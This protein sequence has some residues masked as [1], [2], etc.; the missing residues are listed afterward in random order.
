MPR[1]PASPRPAPADPDEILRC[2]HFGTCGGCS[3]LDQPIRW[4]LHDKVAACERDLAP[5]LG[6]VRID[7][8][9][10]KRP[11]RH[12]RT[13]LL[14]PVLPDHDGLPIV[15]LYGFRSHD[16]VQIE[17]CSTQDGWLTQFGRKA[18][19]VLRGLRLQPF[20]ARRQ[21]GNVKAIWARLA[22]GT[23]EVLAGIVTRPGAFTEG[24]AFAK[25]LVEAARSLPRPRVPRHLQGV[26][27]SI[28]DGDDEFLLGDR[29]VPLRGA[30]HVI[31][32]RDG[33]AFRVSAGSFYQI[34]ADAHELLYR[35]AIAM[36]GD[37]RGQRVVD[38][39]GGVGA[40]GLRL[41]KAGAT[42][43]T[44]VEEGAAACR[45]AEHNAALNRLGGVRVVRSPVAS[46]PLPRQADLMVL[47]PPRAGLQA[48]ACARVVAAAPRRILYVSCAPESLARDLATLRQA[49][50]RVQA[51]RLC[52]LFPHT[53]HCELVVALTS[54]R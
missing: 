23:G 32:R 13:R 17:E 38:A 34:H 18:E 39:Y 19:Q 2:R 47:D 4:Q 7:C 42:E 11:P 33:L 27:H 50:Y 12:F 30:D 6:D 54:S 3:L 20:D 10:P 36:C 9:E 26:V 44:I 37:V 8:V 51:A 29:H 41:A 52:D 5:H 48:R 35:P 14:Y 25:A 31:D 28:S 46:T 22:S 24:P 43:V 1:R 40:F 49:G 53:E 45:D 21:R 16:L 15:G